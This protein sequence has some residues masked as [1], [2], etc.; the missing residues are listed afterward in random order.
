MPTIVPS[1]VSCRRGRLVDMISFTGSD[2]TGS[3][4]MALAARSLKPVVH[5]LG[6]K[7]ALIGLCQ[8]S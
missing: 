6:G 2:R 4:I 1:N 8:L 3:D 5:E 7:S